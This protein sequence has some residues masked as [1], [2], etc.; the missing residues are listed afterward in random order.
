MKIICRYRVIAA[1]LCCSPLGLPCVAQEV[2]PRRSVTTPEQLVTLRREAERNDPIQSLKPAAVGH[3]A[4]KPESLQSLES[5]TDIICYNKMAVRVPK[6]AIIHVP[7]K[8]KE[9]LSIQPDA[10]LES[11]TTFYAANR[12]WITPVEI[13]R[14]Q[15]EGKQPL[16]EE[17]VKQMSTGSN[18]MI[19][20]YLGLPIS[21]LPP[22]KVPEES[23]RSTNP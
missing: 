20:T 14:S 3:A 17:T 22:Q 23:N 5:R 16:S 8:L 11:W 4:P 13:S 12:G 18:L 21:V 7:Q 1:V 9:R 10:R 6:R 19:A 2:K 15:A